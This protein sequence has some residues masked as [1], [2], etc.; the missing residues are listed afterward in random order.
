MKKSFFILF[1]VLSCAG[2]KLGAQCN[3]TIYPSPKRFGNPK[4]W[5][6]GFRPATG[7]E[8]AFFGTF[9]K[10]LIEALNNSVGGFA[11]Y[12]TQN[13]DIL[14]P[15]INKGEVDDIMQVDGE[16]LFYNFSLKINQGSEKTFFTLINELG[17]FDWTLE[18]GDKNGGPETTRL[19]NESTGSFNKPDSVQVH[20]QQQLNEYLAKR[21]IYVGVPNVNIQVDALK[22]HIA[23][24]SVVPLKGPAYVVEII[25]DKK[26]T[27]GEHD[28]NHNDELHIYIGKWK[29]PEIFTVAS[30]QELKVRQNFNLSQPKLSLQ[31][32]VI[33]IKSDASLFDALLQSIDFDSLNKLIMQ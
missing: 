20:I 9:H 1:I 27:A 31:N 21:E 15:D 13:W 25:R 2:G 14:R 5:P 11:S 32:F 12:S 29:T 23:K 10:N 6:Y 16:G 33:I 26:V 30:T 18:T 22:E 3:D 24:I 19:V 17:Y 7:C 4:Y 8:L 28:V